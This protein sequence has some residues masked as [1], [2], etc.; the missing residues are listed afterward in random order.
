MVISLK[1]FSLTT[2]LVP[3][4]KM[5]SEPLVRNWTGKEPPLEEKFLT[6]P[7]KKLYLRMDGELEFGILAEPI[8]DLIKQAGVEVVG[9]ITEKKTEK[10]D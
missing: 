8:L 6:V 10:V 4:S 1:W 5:F 7:E 3:L 9:I 2:N